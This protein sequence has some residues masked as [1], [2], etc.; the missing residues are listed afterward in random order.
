MLCLVT[1]ETKAQK[2][3]EGYYVEFS[4]VDDFFQQD[5]FVFP[6][7][8]GRQ[9][10]WAEL[11]GKSRRMAK[12][13][14]KAFYDVQP[15]AGGYVWGSMQTVGRSIGRTAVYIATGAAAAIV[16]GYI[17]QQPAEHF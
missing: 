7:P 12:S 16:V 6:E 13:H 8:S 2:T 9:R 11:S 17:I 14:M 1:T 10:N 15:S 4:R 5:M 3:W